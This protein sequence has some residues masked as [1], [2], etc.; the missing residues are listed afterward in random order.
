MAERLDLHAHDARPGARAVASDQ[1]TT[2]RGPKPLLLHPWEDIELSALQVRVI[3]SR[4]ACLVRR[5]LSATSAPGWISPVLAGAVAAPR[6]SDEALEDLLRV[7]RL[8]SS[9]A[10]TAASPYADPLLEPTRGL[11]CLS[12]WGS[13]AGSRY[14]SCVGLLVEVGAVQEKVMLPFSPRSPEP[15]SSPS[16]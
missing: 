6:V 14:G 3:A 9:V 12:G 1:G 4:V 13:R 7:R 16:T 2:R 8:G 11:G 5:L 10:A 15:T